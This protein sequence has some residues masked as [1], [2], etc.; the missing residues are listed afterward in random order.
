MVTEHRQLHIGQLLTFH[1][2]IERGNRIIGRASE[3]RAIGQARRWKRMA[4][5]GNQGLNKTVNLF[6]KVEACAKQLESVWDL[7]LLLMASLETAS[8][9][10]REL[11]F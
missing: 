1:R 5:W 6:L 4:T 7:A 9:L 3:I 8:G 2:P 11:G 10:G